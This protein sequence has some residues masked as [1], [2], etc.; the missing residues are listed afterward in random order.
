MAANKLQIIIDAKN[1]ALKEVNKAIGQFQEMGHAIMRVGKWAV[2]GF[3]AVTTGLIASAKSA[4]EFN[5][6]LGQIRTMA[7]IPIADLR[8]EV[9]ALSAEFGIAKEEL[10]SGLYNALSA[11][12][13]KDNV[14]DF[15]RTASKMAVGGAATVTQSV[16]VLTTAIN[17]FQIPAKDADKVADIL[18]TTVRL[19]KTTIGELGASFSQVAPLAA[20]SGV[21]FEEVAA[22]V[23]SLTKQGVPTAQAMTGLRQT[24]VALNKNLGDGWSETMTLQDAMATL[25]TRA[26]GSQTA[27]QKMVGTVEG[28]LPILAM[29]GKNA[30]VAAADLREMGKSAGAAAAAFAEMESVNKVDRILQQ[31]DNVIKILGNETLAGFEDAID[32]ALKMLRELERTGQLREWSAQVVEGVKAVYTQ[33]VA[34]AKFVRDNRELIASVGLTVG[35]ATVA[36]KITAAV[37]ALRNALIAYRTALIATQA[38]QIAASGGAAAMTGQMTLLAAA[39]MKAKLAITALSGAIGIMVAVAVGAG[40]GLRK[41]AKDANDLYETTRKMESSKAGK[42]NLEMAARYDAFRNKF[43]SDTG[44]TKG[45]TEAWKKHAAGFVKAKKDAEALVETMDALPPVVTVPEIDTSPIEDAGKKL[46]RLRK[47]EESL[48]KRLAD[49]EADRAEKA[50]RDE[51][52]G[53]IDRA[54]EAKRQEIQT[55]ERQVAAL[56]DKAKA[57]KEAA[58]A[59]WNAIVEPDKP[60]EFLAKKRQAREDQK[61]QDKAARV[62][63]KAQAELAEARRMAGRGF[64]VTDRQRELIDAANQKDQAAALKDV[65]AGEKIKIEREGEELARLQADRD[66]ALAKFAEQDYAKGVAEQVAKLEEIRKEIAGISLSPKKLA[67]A[68][69]AA[70]PHATDPLTNTAYQQVQAKAATIASAQATAIGSV[71]GVLQQQLAQL[72][73]IAYD[74]KANLK[75]V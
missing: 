39:T 9:M 58:D 42:A 55:I 3:A 51:E 22:A 8:R 25:A 30:N 53:G 47:D 31:L 70:M 29:T 37:V 32:D 72:K 18:F 11:G 35:A 23:A 52:I 62:E 38:A 40:L 74:L 5:K 63:A 60:G 54:I 75:A 56:Q 68:M 33:L 69:A 17:A 65:L 73:T 10:T 2:G 57:E 21:K 4:S 26:G 43:I 13:P 46:E 59:R 64:R 6:Q 66:S 24:I 14:F 15:M 12:V 28:T 27:L 20:A 34:I 36:Y 19:G 1:L 45:L 16:D 44:S 50:N 67:A 48:M 71:E 41:I 7:A 61:T 49:M